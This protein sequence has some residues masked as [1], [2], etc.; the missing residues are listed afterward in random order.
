MNCGDFPFADVGDMHTFAVTHKKPRSASM[1]ACR[2]E[3][4][5]LIYFSSGMSS[6]F[7]NISLHSKI[8]FREEMDKPTNRQPVYV[9]AM[10][11]SQKF[12]YNSLMTYS[13]SQI[14][15]MKLN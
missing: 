4:R 12:T 3:E 10:D 5:I 11:S 6:A 8:L 7:K 15:F 1:E 9:P 2:L 13:H 14:K